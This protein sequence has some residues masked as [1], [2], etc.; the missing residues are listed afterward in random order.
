MTLLSDF[1]GL[2][3][4]SGALI[5]ECGEYR[6]TLWRN[7]PE[8][9]AGMCVNFIMLNP[10]TADHEKDDPTIRR[11]I[12]YARSWGF[13]KLIITNLFALR[14]TDP[15]VLQRHADPVGEGN[16]EQIVAMADRS[17][18][19][20]FAWGNHGKLLG[21]GNEV[22]KLLSE[23]GVMEEFNY[24]LGM[25]KTGEPVH[26]LYQAKD[27]EARKMRDFL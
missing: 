17:H 21:R 6:F 16:D 5:S 4:P 2:L 27:L 13:G 25:N 12:G 8:G 1:G 20:I 24:C 22:R 15:R 9:H 14:S 18:R 7:L 11:C 3:A 26:P 19:I 23:G 10:S